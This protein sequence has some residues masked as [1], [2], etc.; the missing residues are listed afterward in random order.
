MR[1]DAHVPLERLLRVLVTAQRGEIGG[2]DK[3]HGGIA[4]SAYVTGILCVN[5]TAYDSEKSEER[6]ETQ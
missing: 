6:E 4:G 5:E 1:R 3:G 2:R